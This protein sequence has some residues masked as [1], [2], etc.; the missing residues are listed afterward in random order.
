MGL[1]SLTII[2]DMKRLTKISISLLSFVAMFCGMVA[3]SGPKAIPDKDLIKIF[4]DA[5]LANA[6]VQECKITD[7]SL[8]LYEPILERHGY[9]VEDM[10]FTVR[11]IASRKSSRLSDLVGEASKILEQE[12][13]GH[14]YKLVVLDTIDNVARRKYTRAI[15][16]DSIIK[17]RRLSD[18][19]KLHIVIEDLVPGEYTISFDYHIDTTD[20]NR[21]SRVE[22]YL[23]KGDGTVDMRHTLMLSRYRDS[24][25]TRK[26]T[27]DSSFKELHVNMFYHHEK[28]EPRKPGITIKNFEITRIIP[29]EQAVDNLYEEQMGAVIFNHEFMSGGTSKRHKREKVNIDNAVLSAPEP[30]KPAES[31]KPAEEQ[32]S[33]K[34]ATVKAEKPAARRDEQPAEG[35]PQKPAAERP[36]QPVMDKPQKPAAMKP[37]QPG[38]RPQ[39]NN[40]KVNPR[41][42]QEGPNKPTPGTKVD[43]Q[44]R[45]KFDPTKQTAAQRPKPQEL[46]K[47]GK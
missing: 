40:I 38:E 28:D 24:K 3:C 31:E 7:D 44:G 34:P 4:H 33:E 12:Y 1:S 43:A 16:S 35:K 21:N 9:T 5:F 36:Q 29:T 8:L 14:S 25:Y 27:V 11:T 26:Y 39:N 47:Q 45:V 46:N 22:A 19:A 20:E 15:Y 17:V 6:Y 18:S 23:K 37:Q 42:A 32:Q 13:K 2:Y 10:Q 41:A 30:E